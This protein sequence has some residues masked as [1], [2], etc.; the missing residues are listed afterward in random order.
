MIEH[1]R[2]RCWLPPGG[3]IEPGETPL[4]AAARELREET[5][6]EGEFIPLSPVAGTPDGFLAYEEHLAG[7]KGLHM[8]FVFVANVASDRVQA[9][10]EFEHYQWVNSAD[11]LDC[12]QNVRQLLPLALAAGCATPEHAAAIADR[13]IL[14][15]NQR[16]LR[17]LLN[18]YSEDAV[19]FSPKLRARRPETGGFVRGRAALGEWYQD[20]F[21]RLPQLQY[22]KKHITASRDRAVLEYLRINPGE[23]NYMV[24]EIYNIQNGRIAESSVFHG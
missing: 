20:A 3:E 1:K 6:L 19:H 12:P 13:W 10:E 15:F 16:N 7:S 2:L 9:N 8:N 21:A 18:L 24:A 17:E 11:G 5:G 4:E 23:E 14:Y 22:I